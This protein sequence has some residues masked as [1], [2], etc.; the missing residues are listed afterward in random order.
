MERGEKQ[1]LP[2][3]GA[4][5]VYR[6]AIYCLGLITPGGLLN[7]ANGPGPPAWTPPTPPLCLYRGDEAGPCQ[8]ARRVA[9]VALRPL[10]QRRGGKK[11][12]GSSRGPRTAG[13][14][15]DRRLPA[16]P[17]P[18][19]R[20][21]LGRGAE[22]RPRRRGTGSVAAVGSRSPGG[23]PRSR[24]PA[25][26]RQPGE[27]R[28]PRASARR[29]GAPVG[30]RELWGGGRTKRNRAPAGRQRG[31]EPGT[32]RGE[33]RGGRGCGEA[34]GSRGG[35][36]LSGGPAGGSSVGRP[37]GVRATAWSSRGRR[38]LAEA[39]SWRGALCL[40]VL[41]ESRELNPRP[42]EIWIFYFRKYR[43][44]AQSA[45]GTQGNAA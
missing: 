45:A 37:G 32:K 6:S 26:Q 19:K 31:R 2:F 30:G 21:F 9:V 20:L 29:P 36:G 35:P 28:A 17:L 18:Y 13:L 41:A 38:G 14:G 40:I 3:R 34:P 33:P 23:P 25:G 12:A 1:Q 4:R 7:T 44:L 16:R 22:P 43:L 27:P 15:G 10:Q 24:F 8:A 39:S 5:R 11:R 42:Y